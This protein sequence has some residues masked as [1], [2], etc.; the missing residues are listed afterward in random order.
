MGFSAEIRGIDYPAVAIFK[1]NNGDAVCWY[2]DHPTDGHLAAFDLVE[3]KRHFVS[4][5]FSVC[6]CS[7]YMAPI[8]REQKT[9]EC[10]RNV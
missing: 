4:G 3:Q 2:G 1:L 5:S 7:G 9:R 8:R 6:P 10:R